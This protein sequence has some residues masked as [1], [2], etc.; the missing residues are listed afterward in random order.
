MPGAPTNSHHGFDRH[1]RIC[2]EATDGWGDLPSPRTWYDIPIFGDGVKIRGTQPKFR[3]NINRG[4]HKR[5]VSIRRREM[6]EGELRA[7]VY[8]RYANLLLRAG[9]TRQGDNNDLYSYYA[10]Y[11]APHQSLDW[12]GLVAERLTLEADGTTDDSTFTMAIQW[13]G[14]AEAENE[15][16]AS[17][18]FY[19]TGLDAV[20]YIFEHAAIELPDD[21]AVTDVLSF[22]LTVNNNVKRGPYSGTPGRLAYLLAGRRDIELT[23]RELANRQNFMDAKQDGTDLSFEA[24]FT[25]PNGQVLT[26]TLPALDCDEDPE[27]A[28]PES[29]ATVEPR[30]FAKTDGSDDDITWSESAE[31]GTET[32]TTP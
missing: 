14:K 9:L 26:V 12:K 13:I 16:L 7:L 32:E 6:V 2:E 22:S 20:P 10:Q 30:L 1:F 4:G 25:N 28:E 5:K 11:Y 31:T 21:T 18:D 27:S 8:P 17:T 24:T 23:V 3:P 29:E 15:T 19:Y